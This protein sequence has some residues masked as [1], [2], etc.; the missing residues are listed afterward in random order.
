MD[1]KAEHKTTGEEDL[2]RCA[3]DPAQ[4]LESAL[5]ALSAFSKEHP[6][7]ERNFQSSSLT[8]KLVKKTVLDFFKGKPLENCLSD[9]FKK[10]NDLHQAVEA[11]KRY[12]PLIEK[13]KDGTAKERNLAAF[14]LDAIQKHNKCVER[15]RQVNFIEKASQFLCETLGIEKKIPLESKII[16]PV[17]SSFHS[18]QVRSAEPSR[19]FTQNVLVKASDQKSPGAPGATKSERDMFRMKAIMLLKQHNLSVK[20]VEN[21][22]LAIAEEESKEGIVS[23]RQRL[24]A[25]PGEEIELSGQFKR[26][27]GNLK[28]SIPIIETFRLQAKSH[29]TGFP[30]PIQMAGFAFS[31]SL[32]PACP[33]RPEAIPDFYLIHKK[34]EETA[35]ALLPKGH[36]NETA[37]QNLSLKTLAFN[38]GKDDFL[39]LHAKLASSF[40]KIKQEGPVL[41]AEAPPLF[42]S[43][44]ERSKDPV[45]E[46]AAAYERFNDLFIKEQKRHL[47]RTHITLMGDEEKNQR[48]E[49][50]V[51]TF[52]ESYR[53]QTERL[54]EERDSYILFLASLFESTILSL[55]LQELSEVSGFDPPL[56]TESERIVQAVL[57]KQFED[58]FAEIHAPLKSKSEASGTLKKN[59]ETA[60]DYFQNGIPETSSINRLIGEM[61]VYYLSRKGEAG[62]DPRR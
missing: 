20:L 35:V 12:Y 21:G 23:F 61:E 11:I 39:E 57:F 58:F 40:L 46:I 62:S 5:L 16:I 2:S 1:N 10:E 25:L 29:Q 31:D 14:A 51:K 54:H 6:K 19:L 47:Y 44:L 45:G 32:F 26:L 55:F 28:R 27:G 59:L 13:Y 17:H 9:F 34:M 4:V 56:L 38:E 53:Q 52:R 50:L 36:L 37:K 41:H 8:I 60:I 15:R 48:K 3:L 42:F 24:S 30:H 43:T 18:E 49:I 33:L 7:G 22:S